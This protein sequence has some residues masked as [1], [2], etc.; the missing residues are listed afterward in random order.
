MKKVISGSSPQE[1]QAKFW[2]ALRSDMTMIFG[3]NGIEDGH[4]R[5][6]TA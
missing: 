5:P 6:M 4:A 1:L 3:L 2:K